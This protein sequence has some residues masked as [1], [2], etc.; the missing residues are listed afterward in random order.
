MKKIIFPIFF[1][2]FAKLGYAQ[3]NFGA[4]MGMNLGTIELKNDNITTG[5]D[6]LISQSLSILINMDIDVPFSTVFSFRTG[7][8]L[9]IKGSEIDYIPTLSQQY[10][11][12]NWS[13]LY[14][15]NYL[16]VPLFLVARAETDF[17]GK[18]FFGVGPTL[19]LG[20]GGR[21]TLF[22]DAKNGGQRDISYDLVWGNKPV[23]ED[24]RHGYNYLKRF[25]L[26][27][28]AIFAYQLPK[29]GLTFT[30]G[31]NKGLRNIS[32]VEGIN[33]KTSY[34][35]AGIGFSM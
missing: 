30:A 23:P 18:F 2:L 14:R 6:Y 31:Y 20:V 1:L 8:G 29:S 27:L 9:V 35:S 22:A 15:M 33:L 5:E 28:G 10:P 34:F 21:M 4:R 13:L 7:L 12:T 24:A 19:S 16:E 32:P 17:Y 26:G 11:D 3:A 25:D